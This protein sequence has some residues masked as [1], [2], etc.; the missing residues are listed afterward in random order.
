MAVDIQTI[1]VGFDTSGLVKGQQALDATSAAAARTADTA[2]RVGATAKRS[3]DEAARA[4][5]NAERQFSGAYNSLRNVLGSMGGPGGVA[6]AFMGG[7]AAGGIVELARVIIHA[8]GAMVQMADTAAQMRQQLSLA[9]GSA[10]EAEFAYDRLMKIASSAR[11]EVSGLAQTYAQVSR[12]TGELGISQDRLLRVTETLSKAI[13]ISGGSAQSAQ[14]A[15]VQLSQGLASGT[16]RGEEL[17]SIMEQTPRVARALADGL[18]VGIGA[19]RQ[20]GQDGELTAERVVMALEKASKAIDAEFARTEATVGQSMTVLGNSMLHMVGEFDKASGAS[21]WLARNLLEI[22]SAFDAIAESMKSLPMTPVQ[23]LD[24]QIE[25]AK[26]VKERTA[27]MGLIGMAIGSYQDNQIAALQTKRYDEWLKEHE[28]SVAK[29][30]TEIELSFSKAKNAVDAFANDTGNLSKLDQKVAAQRKL[31]T[32]FLKVTK[33]LVE[34]S[35]DHMKAYAAYQQG[36]ANLNEKFADKGGSRSGRAG[37]GIDKAAQEQARALED[38]RRA[39]AEAD[40]FTGDYT[41]TLDLYQASRAKGLLTDEQYIRVVE[42]LIMRQP[43]ARDLTRQLAEAEKSR[44]DAVSASVRR[45]VERQ[46]AISAST[47]AL[48]V[49][50]AQHER[51]TALIGAT[52][53]ELHHVALQEI[54]LRIARVQAEAA[55]DSENQAYAEQIRLLNQLRESKAE[56]FRKTDALN[57]RQEAERASADM[58]S[59]TLRAGES[60]ER[61]ITDSFMR[62]AESGADAFEAMW[63]SFRGLVASTVL[64]PFVQMGASMVTGTIANAMGLNTGMQGL[65]MAGSLYSAASGAMGLAAGSSAAYGALVPGLSVGS[66][67]ASMLAAQTGVFGAEGLA[68]TASAGATAAG[69]SSMLST[70]A[71]AAPYVAAALLVYSLLSKK[72]GGPKQGGSFSTGDDR[73]FTPNTAD[74]LLGGLGSGLL[75]QVGALTGRYG[76]SIA[77]ATVSLG[78]DQDPIGTAGSRIASRVIGADGRV[79]LDNSAGRDVGRDQDKFEAELAIEAQR[80]LLAALQASNLENGFADI[81]GRLDPATAAPDAITNI[82]TLAESLYSLGEAVKGL[83][84]SMGSIANLSATARERLVG[85]AGGLES[86]VSAQQSFMQK[87]FT[88]AER[89]AIESERIGAEFLRVVG[90]PLQ[91]LTEGRNSEQVREAFKGLVLGIDTTTDSGLEAYAALMRMAGPLS[92]WIDSAESLGQLSSGAAQASRDLQAEIDGMTS[93]FGDLQG[94]MAEISPVAETL[95]DAWRSGKREIDAIKAALGIGQS[96]STSQMMISTMGRYQGM[97]D[98]YGGARRSLESQIFE[99]GLSSMSQAGQAAALRERAAGVWGTLQGSADPAAVISEYSDLIIRAIRAEAAS[100][101]AGQQAGFDAEYKA[102]MEA[103]RLAKESRQ[104]QIAVLTAQREAWED[105][106][107]ALE[108]MRDYSREIRDYVSDLRIGDLSIL[109]PTDRIA[110]AAA[111]FRSNVAGAQS[112]DEASQ[113]ALTASATDYLQQV[114]QFYASSGP[115]VSAFNEVTGTLDALG[116]ANAKPADQMTLLQMQIDEAAKQVDHL[117]GIEDAQIELKTATIDTSAAE[118]EALKA[119]DTAAMNAQ[120]YLLAEVRNLRTSLLDMLAILDG[121]RTEQEAQ[122]AQ[123]AA[124]QSQLIEL[125][126]QTAGN[127]GAT[128]EAVNA[129]ASAPAAVS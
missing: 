21:K 14:A 62:S 24:A 48:R 33:D 5:Q 60:I 16:L 111:A 15:M 44:F 125:T 43:I 41:K 114:R 101:V 52:A 17:N 19:L 13:T 98:S 106:L 53:L 90:V 18:G 69:A 22:A 74:S 42:A 46:E 94:A 100:S 20:M 123:N 81:F 88:D 32:E 99:T 108:R 29:W 121:V 72:G 27:G 95:V 7:F 37:G 4:A 36:I 75:D 34:G 89:H 50:L 30:S 65:S 57:A 54:D 87:F 39:M 66:A 3:M 128:A 8:S 38:L 26:G 77:G 64:R 47:E 23:A 78:Y 59:V 76:G 6:A 107:D 31:T 45:D 51:A 73:L 68:M 63:N 97:S 124:A 11:V 28:E 61:T 86:L 129:A 110:Q 117:K 93:R 58:Q 103:Q 118:V 67:Q 35:A 85:M 83:P 126:K 49:E 96:E 25:A 55:L 120:N 71:S 40:G 10:R 80:V 91:A 104:D 82:L 102:A 109:S 2:D 112:G 122:I 116:L 84:G 115:Y 12:A 105:Q 9:S 56:A 92:D 127:T 119:I 70:I 1:G 113:R 79:I